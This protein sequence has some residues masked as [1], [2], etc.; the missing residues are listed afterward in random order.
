MLDICHSKEEHCLSSRDSVAPLDPIRRD[1]ERGADVRPPLQSFISEA[2]DRIKLE[3]P[4]V[5][6]S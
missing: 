5:A 4:I 2:D 1:R 3:L 6:I